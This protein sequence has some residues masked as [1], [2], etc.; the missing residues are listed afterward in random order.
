[1]TKLCKNIFFFFTLF[2]SINI[3]PFTYVAEKQKH[4]KNITILL[5]VIRYILYYIEIFT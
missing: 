2:K 5:F 1:M 3:N 4:T